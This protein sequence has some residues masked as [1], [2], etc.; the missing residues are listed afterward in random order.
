MPA[1]AVWLWDKFL[2]QDGAF[3]ILG[4]NLQDC[5][6]LC[7]FV[8][9]PLFYCSIFF[10]MSIKCAMPTS[11]LAQYVL[12]H[13]MFDRTVL[14]FFFFFFFYGVTVTCIIMS[15]LS[16]TKARTIASKAAVP[17]LCTD[18]FSDWQQQIG[19][20]SDLPFLITTGHYEKEEDNQW[21]MNE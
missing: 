5:V 17:F 6:L 3:D 19:L 16:W 1:K 8:W 2:F 14:F 4:R 10:V 18:R 7:L 15:R 20:S 21:I 11:M 12:N 13:W 9:W